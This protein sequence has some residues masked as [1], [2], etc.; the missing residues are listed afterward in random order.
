MTVFHCSDIYICRVQLH[1]Y[2]LGC[3]KILQV[4]MQLTELLY[5]NYIQPVELFIA[6][7]K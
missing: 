5:A 3:N 7:C 6:N 1:I 4:Y 2:I